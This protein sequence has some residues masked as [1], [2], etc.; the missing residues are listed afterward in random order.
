MVI[1][2]LH[3]FV[4]YWPEGLMTARFKGA[5]VRIVGLDKIALLKMFDMIALF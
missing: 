4:K 2:N 5:L 1:G 3:L